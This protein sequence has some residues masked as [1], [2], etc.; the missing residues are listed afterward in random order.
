MFATAPRFVPGCFSSS[1]LLGAMKRKLT[2]SARTT[3]SL[4]ASPL[5]KATARPEISPT[6]VQA[7]CFS[8]SFA[9][10]KVLDDILKKDLVDDKSATEISDMWYSYHEGKENVHGI[11]LGGKAAAPLLERAATSPFFIQPIFRDDGYFMLVSQFM[12]PS[13]FIMAYLEDYKMD[14]A[15][16]QPL[17]T[18]SVFDDYANDKDLMLVRADVLNKGIN[19]EEG[20][21]VVKSMLDQYVN[22][23]EYLTVK[24][25]NSKPDSFD[26][27]DFIAQKN[28]QWKGDGADSSKTIDVES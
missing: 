11:V 19:D 14:P 4:V 27:D 13:H 25:F 12:E 16:A 23:E 3:S 22:D 21:K 24:A 8:F 15:G 2:L 7:R 26:I 17:L 9:G 1:T 20:L 5:F 10:P 28:I 6:M 18:F